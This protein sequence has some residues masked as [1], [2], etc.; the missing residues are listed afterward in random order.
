MDTGKPQTWDFGKKPQD[1]EPRA[2][3]ANDKG[4]SVPRNDLRRRGAG[5]HPLFGI[6]ASAP[7]RELGLRDFLNIALAEIAFQHVPGAAQNGNG[8][9][10]M[11]DIQHV[12][13]AIVHHGPGLAEQLLIEQDGALAEFSDG[14]FVGRNAIDISLSG[15]RPDARD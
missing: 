14:S 11:V 10:R 3:E 5:V 7:S 4:A 13:T 9:G 12:E 1:V 8:N 6:A 15:A 2:G